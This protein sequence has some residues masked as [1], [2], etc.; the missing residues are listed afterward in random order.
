[1]LKTRITE[2]ELLG[3]LWSSEEEVGHSWP[4][5]THDEDDDLLDDDFLHLPS[6]LCCQNPALRVGKIRWVI[7]QRPTACRCHDHWEDDRDDHHDEDELEHAEHG[8][9]S[10]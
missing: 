1:M 3:A 7:Q 10:M 5:S 4:V 8:R 9:H 2:P 6:R